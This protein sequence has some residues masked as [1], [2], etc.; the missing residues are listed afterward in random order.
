[1]HPASDDSNEVFLYADIPV[2]SHYVAR[3]G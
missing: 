2:F 1:M 3:P